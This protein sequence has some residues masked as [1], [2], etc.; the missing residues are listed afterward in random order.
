MNRGNTGAVADTLTGTLFVVATPIGNLEDITARAASVLRGVGIVAAE[1]TRRSR[2]L[3]AAIGATPSQLLSLGNH[4]ESASSEG[5]LTL[6]LAGAD[7]ALVSDAGTPLVS[8][9]GF[10]LVRAAF[11]AGVTVVPIPGVSAVTAAL[12][13]CP[14]PVSRFQFE[15]F[16]PAKSGQRQGRL[17]ALADTAVALVCFESAR[18]LADTLADIVTVMGDRQV[19]LA[20]EI[21]KIH[22]TF[23]VG[24]ASELGARAV[25]ERD[26]A[27]GE[28]VLVIAPDARADES[29]STAARALIRHLCDELPPSQAARIA[30]RSL[31]IAKAQAYEFALSVRSEAGQ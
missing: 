31:G 13:V 22:E 3:L 9:P 17:A 11:N 1:D 2:V 4:N 28:Y 14:L 26:F 30:A 18:R 27:R 5:V 16:L 21:S 29:L 6:L 12:S 25:A 19:F 23:L 7:V 8:D 15:G 20:K 24:S 10:E